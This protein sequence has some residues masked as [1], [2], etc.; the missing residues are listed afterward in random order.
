MLI[1][2]EK[3]HAKIQTINLQ[4]N[5]MSFFGIRLFT[6]SSKAINPTT[7]ASKTE[8]TPTTLKLF[9]GEVVQPGTE[10]RSIDEL[11]SDAL[12]NNQI[13]LVLFYQENLLGKFTD[14]KSVVDHLNSLNDPS[15]RKLDDG[16]LILNI[17]NHK[18]AYDEGRN[19][20]PQEILEVA[21]QKYEV[22][23]DYVASLSLESQKTVINR[24]LISSR[25]A[26]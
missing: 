18:D 22:G 13:G 8:Q 20:I 2:I 4:E 7:Q 15:R 25:T 9:T 14:L 23:M 19:N 5:F 3:I 1:F 11:M 24:A 6:G 26:A 12:Q 16:F 10:N 17:V 21:Q